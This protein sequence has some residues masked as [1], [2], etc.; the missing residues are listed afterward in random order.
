MAEN[1]ATITHQKLQ[2]IW[3]SGAEDRIGVDG[4]SS[5][6]PL[7][8]HDAEGL[9]AVHIGTITLD[10]VL[11]RLDLLRIREADTGRKQCDRNA[12]ALEI[13]IT[14]V[15]NMIDRTPRASDHLHHCGIST[16]GNSY[17]CHGA[18][19][20]GAVWICPACELDQRD[21]HTNGVR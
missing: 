19:C 16:C 11:I 3:T 18:R 20:A 21:T 5:H 10:E 4:F 15:Q 2:D 1:D 7:R 8:I 17:F 14:A 9:P 12:Q 13:A 6:L